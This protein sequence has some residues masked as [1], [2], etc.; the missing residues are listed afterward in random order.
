ME[1]SGSGGTTSAPPMTPQ[2][3]ATGSSIPKSIPSKK[4]K[5]LK[6][7]KINSLYI[8]FRLPRPTKQ[9]IQIRHLAF[10]ASAFFVPVRIV[11][12]E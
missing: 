4:N 1:S 9:A 11:L 2:R 12:A 10:I 6:T 7:L 5:Q 8:Q 3:I